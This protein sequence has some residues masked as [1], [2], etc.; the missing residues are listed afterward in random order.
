MKL[1]QYNRNN[2]KE[3]GSYYSKIGMMKKKMETSIDT[4]NRSPGSG[5]IRS[6]MADWRP[7]ECRSCCKPPKSH[8]IAECEHTAREGSS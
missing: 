7:P 3:N 4:F 8:A 1:L 5:A 6:M 2:G